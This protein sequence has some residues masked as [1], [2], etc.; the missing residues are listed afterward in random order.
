MS[1]QPSDRRYVEYFGS[2]SNTASLLLPMV[3]FVTFWAFVV[4]PGLKAQTRAISTVSLSISAGGNNAT[5][6]AAGTVVALTAS[7]TAGG[8]PVTVGQVNF[9]DANASD[10]IGL[11]RIAAVQVNGTGQAIYRFQPGSG[12]QAFKAIF[13]GTNTVARGTSGQGFLT[14]TAA[15][16]SVLSTTTTTT[17]SGSWGN[18][19]LSAM[20]SEIG[21]P[22]AP[23]GTVSFVDTTAS[24]LVL[25]HADLGT[26]KQG[27]TWLDSTAMQQVGSGEVVTGDFNEDGIVDIALNQSPFNSPATILL[28]NGDGTFTKAFSPATCSEPTSILVG[29]FN[30]DGHQDLA[31]QCVSGFVAILLGRGDGTF[32]TSPGFTAIQS[33]LDAKTGDFNGDGKTDLVFASGYAGSLSIYFGNGDGTFTAGPSVTLSRP[34]D[35]LLAADLD[36]DGKTD[37]IV[38]DDLNATVLTGNGDGTFFAAA[39]MSLP[40]TAGSI[41][42]ADFNGDGKLDFAVGGF[43]NVDGRTAP[44][45]I[46][47]GNGDGTFSAVPSS[48]SVSAANTMAV[49]DFNQDGIPDL[50]VNNFLATGASVLLGKGDGTFLLSSVTPGSSSTFN[51]GLGIAD[52]NGDGVPDIAGVPE[53]S[54]LAISLTEPTATAVTPAVTIRP[55]TPGVHLVQATYPGSTLYDAS[56][57]ATARLLGQ[58]PVTATTLT[59]T[60]GGT[61]VTS[62]PANTVVTLIATVTAG[63]SPVSSGLVNFCDATAP[64]C[65]DIHLIASV[66]LNSA[67]SATFRFVPGSGSYQ[68]K[69]VFLEDAAGVPSSSASASLTVQSATLPSATTTTSLVESGL[70]G[71][72]TLTATVAGIGRSEAMSGSVS[73]Q[74]TSASNAVLATA[75]LGAGI[76]GIGWI[77][78]F[79]ATYANAVFLGFAGGDFNGDGHPDVAAISEGGTPVAIHLGNGD[80]TFTDATGLQIANQPNAIVSGD[81]NGDG[82][83]DLAVSSY[84]WGYPAQGYMTI[85]LGNGD[86]TFAAVSPSLTVGPPSE[87]MVFLAAADINGDGKL[88]LILNEDLGTRILFGNGDGTFSQGPNGLPTTYAVADLNGD[89]V[90]DLVASPN[91]GVAAIYLGNGD[92]TF[93]TSAT[94]SFPNTFNG[95]AGVADFNGDG[96]PDLALTSSSYSPVS[97]WLGKGDGTFTQAGNAGNVSI[98]EPVSIG[99]G[100]FNHDGKVDIVVG[101]YNSYETST[102]PDLTLLLGNGDGTFTVGAID[103]QFGHVAQILTEDLDGDG[104]PDLVLDTTNMTA[105]LTKPTQTATATATGI[106]LTGPGTHAVDAVYGGDSHYLTSTSATTALYSQAAAPQLSLTGG[107]YNSQQTLSIT[108]QTAGASIYYTLYGPNVSVGPLY[109][110]R[111]WRCLMAAHTPSRPMLRTPVTSRALPRQRATN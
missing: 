73:F 84:Y 35:A 40:A 108:D 80:G 28:G 69:A 29:D 55:G 36:G 50:V 82:I 37:L 7:V 97:I 94:L 30:Q 101:N 100:D 58:P 76:A 17:W 60:A 78:S 25:G 74:D 110:P 111:R 87:E 105:L 85:F 59:V 54:S 66:Q 34:A 23:A 43:N 90:P 6:I 2:A 56:A 88:D 96:I 91:D 19:V 57:S 89:G 68:Y 9:C 46:F 18:Y 26:P 1:S 15:T 20:V 103:T 95:S 24:N 104:T 72:Y 62:I 22:I 31:V 106:A 44:I 93:H 99:L 42:A 27:T 21:S 92:G 77:S 51:A 107:T 64:L 12:S 41:V 70:V 83:L 98:N 4:T 33:F 65:T 67:G 63:G 16:P 53:N 5:T 49:A 86:G 81:F 71:N 52:L 48:S 61:P 75:P 102:N 3:V 47:L 39:P 13:A 32:T 45:T 14:V 11:H 10:C 109:T 8:A 38:G 79:T